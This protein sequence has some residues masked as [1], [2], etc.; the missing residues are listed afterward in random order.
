MRQTRSRQRRHGE[1]TSARRRAPR[2]E[3]QLEAEWRGELSECRWD[4][5]YATASY[6]QRSD[7]VDV[8]PEIPAKHSLCFAVHLRR[9]GL[10]AETPRRGEEREWRRAKFSFNQKQYSSSLPSD[11]GDSASRR[12]LCLLSEA[13]P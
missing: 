13:F 12:S 4:R 2:T 5:S 9:I 8:T 7:R 1:P 10:N 3:F 6:F 11:L